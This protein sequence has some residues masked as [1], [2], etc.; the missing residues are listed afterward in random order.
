[1][2]KFE[3]QQSQAGACEATETQYGARQ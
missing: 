1:M 3:H 2:K